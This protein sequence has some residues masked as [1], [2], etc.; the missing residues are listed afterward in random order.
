MKKTTWLFVVA[1]LVVGGIGLY[2]RL[3]FGHAAAGYSSPI[4]WG[5]WVATYIFLIGLSAGAFLLSTLVYVFRIKEIESLGRLALLTALAT[6]IAALVTIW[7]D[8]G[9][10]GRFW[11][12]FASPNFH[13]AM[14]WMVW[15]YTAY[16]LLLLAELFFALR[17]DLIANPSQEMSAR[18][19]RIL[20]I[21]GIIGIPLAVTFHGGVGTL[22]AVVQARPYW[23]T[24]LFPI[25]FLVSALSSGSALL[26]FVVAFV[27][28]DKTSQKFKGALKFLAR[29]VVGLLL[30][31]LL[32]ELAEFIVG[33]YA[34]APA[35]SLPYH[36]ILFGRNWWVFWL[37]HLLIG[38]VIPI[39]LLTGK[40]PS[41]NR[42]GWGA[43]LIVLGFL[44]VRYNIVIPGLE[45]PLFPT[46]P[47]AYIEA[48]LN[49]IYAP[50]LN[51]WLV[52]LFTIALGTAIFLLGIA[53]L[54]VTKVQAL[55]G[56]RTGGV[57]D[58]P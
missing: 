25:L 11:R 15:L 14:A 54:P 19:K 7:L 56:K 31:D 8:L 23:N 58:E 28:P 34:T 41:A 16:F 9:Q 27:W 3:A 18:D 48:K 50:T 38:A 35:H 36:L 26:T 46:L 49:Y 30:I 32:F 39:V 2:Q 17:G 29:V 4:P 51:E 53:I 52:T 42:I 1:A 24:S 40:N 13:S 20:K 37:V 10:M 45:V 12:V 33:T 55:P 57:V 44:G 6:L 21:L 47:K 43:L 5:L 22:F